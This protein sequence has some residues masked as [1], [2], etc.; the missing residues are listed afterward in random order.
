MIIIILLTLVNHCY[1]SIVNHYSAWLL[2]IVTIA[3]HEI[4]QS[5][6]R[7]PAPAS[8][9]FGLVTGASGWSTSAMPCTR[10]TGWYNNSAK[11]SVPSWHEFWP[12]S[13]IP[14][15][16]W[17]Y[18][19]FDVEYGVNMDQYAPCSFESNARRSR[20]PPTELL[21]TGSW[22]NHPYAPKIIRQ[23]R[24]PFQVGIDLQALGDA[25]TCKEIWVH[26]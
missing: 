2:T 11:M 23:I 16:L 25:R 8:A 7:A 21:T 17:S 4:S 18:P 9:G 3:T 19:F 5:I 1:T 6:S 24:W 10:E 13:P 20:V 15:V 26:P 22:L 14:R 12:I